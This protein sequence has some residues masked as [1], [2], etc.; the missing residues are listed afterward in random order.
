MHVDSFGGYPTHYL[1]YKY[2]TYVAA[3]LNVV[4]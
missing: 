4:Y 3:P 2:V 1:D